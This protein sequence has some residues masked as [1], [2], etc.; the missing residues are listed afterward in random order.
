MFKKDKPLRASKLFAFTWNSN[1]LS[2]YGN[3]NDK[4]RKEN[5]DQNLFNLERFY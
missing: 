1:T 3:K 4:N 5:S 2:Q